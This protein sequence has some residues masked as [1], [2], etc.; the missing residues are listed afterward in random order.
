MADNKKSPD[1]PSGVPP[2]CWSGTHRGPVLAAML[3][4]KTCRL[5]AASPDGQT[6]EF[7]TRP[8]RTTILEPFLG[9]QQHHKESP[10]PPY[11]PAAKPRTV[12]TW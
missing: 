6:S 9:A 2:R 8:S 5:S 12:D 10:A 1:W 11:T 4:K 7:H 3:R